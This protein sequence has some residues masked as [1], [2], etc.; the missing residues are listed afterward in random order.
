MVQRAGDQTF[1]AAEKPMTAAHFLSGKVVT[2]N[3][4]S[5]KNPLH[6]WQDHARRRRAAAVLASLR[7]GAP[8]ASEV[9]RAATAEPDPAGVHVALLKKNFPRQRFPPDWVPDLRDLGNLARL[10]H[11]FSRRLAP[12]RRGE[13]SVSDGIEELTAHFRRRR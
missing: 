3:Q 11:V 2:T 8:A 7:A 12:L 10:R 9:I 4:R 6:W 1:R 13:P 5:M